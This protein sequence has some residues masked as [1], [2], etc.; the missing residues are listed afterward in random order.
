MFVR[1]DSNPSWGLREAEE[2]EE[3]LR[4]GGGWRCVCGGVFHAHRVHKA[5]YSSLAQ[6]QTCTRTP[7]LVQ[8]IK[9][10]RESEGESGRRKYRE[11]ERGSIWPGSVWEVKDR[12]GGYIG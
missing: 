2:G 9:L 6:G 7:T 1:G 12:T 11:R 10:Q 8:L 3:E 5:P 4:E